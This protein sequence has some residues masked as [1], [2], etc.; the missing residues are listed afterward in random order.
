MSLRQIILWTVVLTFAFEVL[1]VALRFGLELDS[2]RDTAPYL[3]RLTFGYRVHHGYVGV[4]LVLVAWAL[5]RRRRRA[6]TVMLILGLSLI[7]S[8]LMHH[9]AVLWPI[10]GSPQFDLVYPPQP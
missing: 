10:T 4:L 7:S 8:D 2:T 6:A 1:C 5:A 9:F 3:S